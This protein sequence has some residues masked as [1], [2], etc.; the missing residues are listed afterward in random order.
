MQPQA[1]VE[2][3]L[4]RLSPQQTNKNNENDTLW[5]KNIDNDCHDT[6]YD[7][8]RVSERWRDPES[9]RVLTQFKDISYTFEHVDGFQVRWSGQP[10]TLKPGETARMPRYLGEHFAYHLANHI[11]DKE[12]E[13]SNRTLRS[14][15]IWRPKILSQIIIKEEPFFAMVN[16][17]VGA[18][19]MKQVQSL[20][21]GNA[22]LV[23]VQGLQYENGGKGQE[24]PESDV[25]SKDSIQ[26]T[27]GKI[28]L[29]SVETTEDVITRL[30]EETQVDSLNVPDDWKQYSKSD[31]IM[32]I[33]N[34]A[35]DYKFGQNY[36]KAQL[37][38]ILQRF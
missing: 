20:N 13:K 27:T 34:M 31:L 36:T 11:L 16:D 30:G 32:Q 3:R 38:G 8:V 10:F 6:T 2:E 21:D 37:V 22:P 18:E 12:G 15:P 9:G 35:P 28:D 33:R 25:V 26:T 19:T 5:I 17:S 14:D 23:E 24:L 7:S 1:D 29:K 4:E